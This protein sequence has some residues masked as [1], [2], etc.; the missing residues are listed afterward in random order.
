MKT[1]YHPQLVNV[2]ISYPD[3]GSVHYPQYVSVR[4]PHCGMRSVHYSQ[5]G[6]FNFAHYQQWPICCGQLELKFQMLFP[7]IAPI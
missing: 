2:F 3:K 4:Y 1:A 6:R 7:L 5:W